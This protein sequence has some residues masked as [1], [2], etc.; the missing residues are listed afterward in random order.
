VHHV[1]IF[2]WYNPEVRRYR[3]NFELK[4]TKKRYL[5]NYCESIK[6]AGRM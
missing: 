4:K 6:E 1:G 2:E 5:P 3:P